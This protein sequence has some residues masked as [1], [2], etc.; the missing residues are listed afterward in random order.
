MIIDNNLKNNKFEEALN[1][2]EKL[3]EKDKDYIKLRDKIV[4]KQKAYLFK[5]QKEGKIDIMNYIDKF[6]T[7]SKDKSSQKAISLMSDIINENSSKDIING[8]LN[9]SKKICKKGLEKNTDDI[10]LINAKALIDIKNG[11][12]SQAKNNIDKALQKAP[13]NENLKNNKFQIFTDEFSNNKKLTYDD[14]AFI[15]ESISSK[16][17]DT[18]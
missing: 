8:D 4:N 10:N 13:K 16:K 11:D 18:K 17:E 6:G 14:K 1:I 3:I 9:K 2:C 15:K 7:Y 5:Q 12:L